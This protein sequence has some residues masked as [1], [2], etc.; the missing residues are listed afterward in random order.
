MKQPLLLSNIEK[1]ISFH[2]SSQK[3]NVEAL[4]LHNWQVRETDRQKE[5]ED[6]RRREELEKEERERKEIIE[7]GD[8]DRRDEREER[9]RTHE[10]EDKERMS[11]FMFK[12]LGNNLQQKVQ[13]EIKVLADSEESES[14]PLPLKLK[15]SSISSLKKY[16]LLLQRVQINH[17]YLQGLM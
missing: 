15:M 16:I 6:K 14:Q 17:I 13:K 3:S 1:S 12:L 10:R 8:W 7:R 5:R 9:M 4:I 2:V 11:M